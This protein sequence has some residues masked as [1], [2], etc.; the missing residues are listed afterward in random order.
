MEL[1]NLFKITIYGL[2]QGIGFRPYVA[3]M[4]NVMGL[5]GSVKNAG[6]IVF[7]YVSGEN[8][9]IE[10]LILKLENC[11]LPGAKITKIE[12]EEID[13]DEFE[14]NS[15]GSRFI[16]DKS[17]KLKDNIRLLP[18]DLCIC[19]KC[20][21]ELF[22]KNNR[23]YRY[24]FISCVS[25]GPRYSII[26]EIPYDRENITMN[27][28]VMC[29]ACAS[30]YRDEND[31]RCHAQ[32]I[33]CEECGPKLIYKT[34]S[35]EITG[36][37]KDIT[38]SIINR[39][40]EALENGKIVAIKDIG[41]FH[42][43]VK[44]DNDEAV[45]RLKIN[46]NR[47]TKP[48]AVMFDNLED[49]KHLCRVS[50][51]EEKIL[52]SNARPIVL[53]EMI[54][55]DSRLVGEEVLCGSDR[56]GAM[57][58]VNPLQVLLLEKTGPLV[59]TSGNRS[60]EPILIEDKDMNVL[61]EEGVIDVMLSND[62]RIVTPLEDS[63]LQVI[64]TKAKE[65]VQFIRRAR[66][67]VPEIIWTNEKSDK[68][69][70]ATGGDLKSSFALKKENAVCISSYYGDLE[71]YRAKNAWDKEL[72]RMLHLLN[73]EEYDVVSDAH[74]L[75]IS[76]KEAKRRVNHHKAHIAS[77]MA[78]HQVTDCVGVAFDGTGY[79]ED[80]NIWGSEFF[81]CENKKIVRGAHFDYVKMSA[82]D[83]A[84][85]NAQMSLLAYLK[86]AVKEGYIVEDS[87]EYTGVNK[88]ILDRAFDNNINVIL[89]S[90]TGRLFDAVSALLGVCNY[91][92]YEGECAAK[93]EILARKAKK[94]HEFEI[95]YEN[96]IINVV[97]LMADIYN[98]YNQG[99]DVKSLALG[100]HMAIVDVTIKVIKDLD[101]K[102]IKSVC[103]S[104]GT[105]ANR[106][107]TTNIID[108]LEKDEYK[109]YMN[110]K[111]PCNDG[112]ISLGQLFLE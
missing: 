80:G 44:A 85:K 91:N 75:Y 58:Y 73:I 21:K 87:F 27:E 95:D 18:E 22:D 34:K 45:K 78:E 20:A 109:V 69:V 2:V 60:G 86:R 74:P 111:V 54:K 88:T 8:S 92:S 81:I 6:G 79:G 4:A 67:Y 68:A 55:N 94:A 5:S 11:D 105:F 37:K 51:E 99:I 13:L 42:F 112:G 1:T 43:C 40:V 12:K 71:D 83:T 41:G 38:D 29:E 3:H 49:I 106:I 98:A 65:R 97:K 101:K 19:D 14:K 103:L 61:L 62:R 76:A 7:I 48:L 25:C 93:L 77:V 33:G 70:L 32:T 26:E 84:S 104:G 39:T 72:K 82:S 110:E 10:N 90:S 28:F 89:S 53:L 102:G 31:R 100:F 30:E 46:K 56:L 64:K 107:L 17:Q 52:L 24:P 108:R 9:R 23:R 47:P 50:K 57:L 16:I 15:K 66:G 36:R 63:I 96:G 59:M 35:E